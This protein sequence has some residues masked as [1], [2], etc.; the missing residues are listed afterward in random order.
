MRIYDDTHPNH[1]GVGRSFAFLNSESVKPRNLTAAELLRRCVAFL[2]CVV[3]ADVRISPV[4]PAQQM[5][6]GLHDRYLA[7]A[8]GKAWRK[9]ACGPASREH[10]KL[11][12]ALASD[13]PFRKFR[14]LRAC[15][16]K[17]PAR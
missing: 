13:G 11:G 9:R 4:L 1:L 14:W 8:A 5:S 6:A 3:A 10:P 7:G 2:T 17:M 15:G 16:E 12:T